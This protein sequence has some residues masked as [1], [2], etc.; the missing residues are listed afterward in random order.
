MV[1]RREYNGMLCPILRREYLIEARK[2]TTK[3]NVTDVWDQSTYRRIVLQKN[4]I[5]ENVVR[6]GTGVERAGLKLK[7][8][9]MK[10]LAGEIVSNDLFLGEIVIENVESHP[11]EATLR[12]NGRK[13]QFKLDSGADVIV[14]P[15]QIYKQI[16]NN[17]MLETTNQ[18]YYDRLIID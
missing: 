9:L 14:V 6:K 3:K 16:A 5:A 17:Q 1:L 11:W 7:T 4:R 8:L 13:F 10:Q 2:T 15:P 12:L 18:I